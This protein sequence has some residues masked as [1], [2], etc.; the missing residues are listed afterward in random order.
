MTLFKDNRP[1]VKAARIIG[2]LGIIAAVIYNG[3]GLI[4]KTISYNQ[5]RVE[6]NRLKTQIDRLELVFEEKPFLHH[7]T[8]ARI[9]LVD[10]PPLW[11]DNYSTNIN[12]EREELSLAYNVLAG[13]SIVP[14]PFTNEEIAQSV[15]NSPNLINIGDGSLNLSENVSLNPLLNSIK[16]NNTQ[17]WASISAYTK[18]INLNTFQENQIIYSSSDLSFTSQGTILDSLVLKFDPGW[19]LL[20]TPINSKI[21]IE[22]ILGDQINDLTFLYE[23]QAGDYNVLNTKIN[24]NDLS[25]TGEEIIYLEPEKSYWVFADSTV[26][27]KI[28]GKDFIEKILTIE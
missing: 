9:D 4:E 7:L 23:P 21:P 18:G 3:P 19:N 26:S 2:T 17:E 12:D 13:Y 11:E 6:T 25:L 28:S 22:S 20:N 8:S 15:I 10:T 5:V 14:T 16:L 24:L 27:R 1:S